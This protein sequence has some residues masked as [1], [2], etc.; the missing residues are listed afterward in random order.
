MT[1]WKQMKE[2]ERE[3]EHEES[4]ADHKDEGRGHDKG[5]QVAYR[6]CKWPE[7]GLSSR[8]SRKN[9]PTDTLTLAQ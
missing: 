6:N 9:R 8:I 1:C 3:R 7:K 2:R 5:M 4:I